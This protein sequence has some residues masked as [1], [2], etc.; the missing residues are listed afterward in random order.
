[1]LAAPVNLISA[2]QLAAIVRQLQEVCWCV[3]EP[4]AHKQSTAKR[5][6][7]AVIRE[8]LR[9]SR[10]I[11][12]AVTRMTMG[13]ETPVTSLV[14]P[15][16]LR[17]ILTKVSPF[18]LPAMPSS[19]TLA[20]ASPIRYI[21]ARIIARSRSLSMRSTSTVGETEC[22]GSADLTR[23]SLEGRELAS[24]HHARPH[25]GHNTQSGAE[26]RYERERSTA[27]GRCFRLRW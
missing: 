10:A 26:S 11:T 6:R 3:V 1:M 25:H 12:H 9:A 19:R 5:S 27:T 7:F 15:V 23:G 8:Y 13:D 24:W 20:H 2:L 4:L 16:V 17:P 18:M 22:H 14:L 21:R